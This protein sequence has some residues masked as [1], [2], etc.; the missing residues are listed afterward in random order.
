[1]RCKYCS[2]DM[3]LDSKEISCGVEV[4][5]YCCPKCSATCTVKEDS[6]DSWE[7]PDPLCEECFDSMVFEETLNDGTLIYSCTVCGST[8]VL[9]PM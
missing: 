6:E 1:M 5:S 8:L 7:E 9:E 4:H 2:S 3:E